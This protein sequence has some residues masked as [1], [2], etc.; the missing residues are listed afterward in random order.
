[1]SKRYKSSIIEMQA[2]PRQ[3]GG[4]SFVPVRQPQGD[5]ELI[6]PEAAPMRKAPQ[7][8][9]TV[10]GTH[11]NRAWAFSVKTWQISAVVGLVAWLI[12]GKLL[13]NH[14]LLSLGALAWLLTGFG[15]V[16][17]G[18]YVLDALVSPEGAELL[19]TLLFWRFMAREQK[20]RHERLR[21]SFMPPQKGKE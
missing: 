20:E 3:G 21:Q 15:L 13:A 5:M 6:P 17:A 16:W 4:M 14:P 12:G 9:V 7:N 1:M 2:L 11:L 19:D 8:Q 18:A 10:T